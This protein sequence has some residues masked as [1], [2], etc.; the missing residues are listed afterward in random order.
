MTHQYVISEMSCNGY[1]T[2]AECVLN[3]IKDVQAVVRLEPPTA[4]IAMDKHVAT[5]KIHHC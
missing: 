3:T 4:N 1:R 2:K 5:K